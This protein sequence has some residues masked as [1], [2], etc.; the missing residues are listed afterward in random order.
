MYYSQGHLTKHVAKQDNSSFPKM[1][2]KG[3]CECLRSL[4]YL[5]D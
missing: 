1:I 4:R 5:L 2:I 3:E